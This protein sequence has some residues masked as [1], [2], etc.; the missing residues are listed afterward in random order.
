MLVGMH[1]P[2]PLSASATHY[3]YGHCRLYWSLMNSRFPIA[4]EELIWSSNVLLR[5]QRGSKKSLY[6]A[7]VGEPLNYT[8][9]VCDLN[10]PTLLTDRQTSCL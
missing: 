3:L 7:G 10:P 4:V 8:M 2:Y 1:L 9:Y 6:E 5:N